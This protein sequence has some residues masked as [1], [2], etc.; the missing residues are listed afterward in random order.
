M[1]LDERAKNSD[2]LDEFERLIWNMERKHG[3]LENHPNVDQFELKWIRDEIEYLKQKLG[4]TKT[5][6][7][8]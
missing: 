5:V 4:R 6:A 3:K 2:R 8:K 7:I 1:T